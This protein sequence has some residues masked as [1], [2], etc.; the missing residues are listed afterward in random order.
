ML[1]RWICPRKNAASR[2]WKDYLQKEIRDVANRKYLGY[3]NDKERILAYNIGV[4]IYAINFAVHN[5]QILKEKLTLYDALIDV[6]VHDSVDKFRSDLH[7][8]E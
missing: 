4:S 2:K 8:L 1:E 3:K 6:N 7:S 5:Y